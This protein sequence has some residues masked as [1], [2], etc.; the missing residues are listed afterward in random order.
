MSQESLLLTL[1]I[2]SKPA[3]E[4]ISDRLNSDG[5]QVIRSFDLQTA[6]AAHESCTCPY[7]GEAEC[8]CQLVVLLVYD[9]QGS[10]LKMVVHSKGNKT[11]FA[12]TDPPH[13]DQERKIKI[14]I[15][16]ALA[17]EGFSTFKRDDINF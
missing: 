14:K 7:H 11:H 3:I 13:S 6:K 17:L 5:M 9:D 4:R 10:L 12:L 1:N 16:Q 8:D 15:L 2:S